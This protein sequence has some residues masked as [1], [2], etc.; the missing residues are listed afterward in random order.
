MKFKES[1]PGPGDLIMD[2]FDA[3]PRSIGHVIPNEEL[4]IDAVDANKVEVQNIIDS[5]TESI[6]ETGPDTVPGIVSYEDICRA[7]NINNPELN[8]LLKNIPEDTIVIFKSK[9]EDKKVTIQELRDNPTLLDEIEELEPEQ[10][11]KKVKNHKKTD[12]PEKNVRPENFMKDV[13]R[14]EIQKSYDSSEGKTLALDES[15]FANQPDTTKNSAENPNRGISLEDIKI[16]PKKTVPS[17]ETPSISESTPISTPIKNES[18]PTSGTLENLLSSAETKDDLIAIIERS[19]DLQDGL[20]GTQ[21]TYSRDELIA[22]I[23]AN[24]IGDV[25]IDHLPRTAGFREAVDRVREYERVHLGKYAER[26]TTAAELDPVIQAGIKMGDALGVPES[27]R[28]YD[29]NKEDNSLV[30]NYIKNPA[31]EEDAKKNASI[32]GRLWAK[33]KGKR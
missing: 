21:Q 13:T 2:E 16:R 26:Q 3:G 27:S 17:I 11:D 10:T 14:E 20:W 5:I 15:I 1:V 32:F 18:T 24:W 30:Y 25:G 29:H 22:L 9:K 33:L 31:T 6:S 23:E 7:R 8:H 12:H 28:I 19:N 4:K